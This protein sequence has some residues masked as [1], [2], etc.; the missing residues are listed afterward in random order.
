ME[1]WPGE[2]D[3]GGKSGHFSVHF[4]SGI[5]DP[6]MIILGLSAAFAVLLM[7]PRFQKVVPLDGY[8]RAGDFASCPRILKD[9]LP[10]PTAVPEMAKN[11]SFA[12][13]GR[14]GDGKKTARK[15]IF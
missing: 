14:L 7:G 3:L 1:F 9:F 6:Q 15:C 8:S 11:G 10:D 4:R 13:A 12:R 2:E 5:L